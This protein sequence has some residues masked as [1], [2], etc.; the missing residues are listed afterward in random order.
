MD[1]QKEAAKEILAASIKE[2][3]KFIWK[4]KIQKSLL[5][6]VPRRGAGESV[7]GAGRYPISNKQQ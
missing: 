4:F 3:L 7:W 5:K 2:M 1:K 6:M